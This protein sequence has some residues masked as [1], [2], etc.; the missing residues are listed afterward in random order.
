[1]PTDL[2]GHFVNLSLHTNTCPVHLL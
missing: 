1:M 2:I